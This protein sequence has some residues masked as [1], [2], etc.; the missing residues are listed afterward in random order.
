MNSS[1]DNQ[2]SNNQGLATA[3]LVLGILSIV[4]SLAWIISIPLGI[5]AIIFGAVSIKKARGKALAG[6]ITGI[7]GVIMSILVFM[8]VYVALPALQSGQRDTARKNDA[9]IISTEILSYS[10][11]NQGVL[12]G[13]PVLNSSQLS[14]ITSIVETGVPTEN[15]AVYKAG[16]SCDGTASPRAYAVTILLENGSEYCQGS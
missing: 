10:T 16:A 11:T 7:A 9:S 13:A 12:P 2:Q 8:M 5:L 4:T 15:T 6:L 3:A 1:N 14:V